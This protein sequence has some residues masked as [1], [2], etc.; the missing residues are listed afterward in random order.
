METVKALE[1]LGAEVIGAACIADRRAD[2]MRL[3]PA[4]FFPRSSS[5]STPTSRT[6]ARSAKREISHWK[7]P[8]AESMPTGK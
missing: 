6:T 5:Q 7:S 1:D 2:D 8:A 3:T 4:R